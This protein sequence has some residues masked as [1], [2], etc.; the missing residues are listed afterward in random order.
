MNF[1]RL[2]SKD[3]SSREID[4]AIQQSILSAIVKM[5]ANG[6]GFNGISKLKREIDS[7]SATLYSLVILKC[8]SDNETSEKTFL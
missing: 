3:L 4:G 6:M 8:D 7:L 2:E 1:T 5:A